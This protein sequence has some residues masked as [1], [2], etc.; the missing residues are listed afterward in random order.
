MVTHLVLRGSVWQTDVSGVDSDL[1]IKTREEREDFYL[2]RKLE[3]F[4]PEP[5]LVLW[6][7][8]D[9]WLLLRHALLFYLQLLLCHYKPVQIYPFVTSGGSGS[10]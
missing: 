9:S 5:L 10:E 6:F 7:Y 8:Y 3:S 1:K 4:Y 2:D